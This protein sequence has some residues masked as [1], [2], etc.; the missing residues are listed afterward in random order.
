ME[1]IVRCNNE[2]NPQSLI[3]ESQIEFLDEG[4][5]VVTE[6]DFNAGAKCEYLQKSVWSN[7][8]AKLNFLVYPNPFAFTGEQ[9]E[10]S[11]NANLENGI[12]SLNE[13]DQNALKDITSEDI[14]N[15]DNN[16]QMYRVSFIH[17]FYLLNYL[18]AN[19]KSKQPNK[20]KC[21]TIA[22]E[23]YFVFFY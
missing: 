10:F 14:M 2:T 6:K 3:S 9:V 1:D 13:N 11:Q 12:F 22:P 7:V 5:N 19:G 17:A 23:H 16:M 15:V 18:L 20:F 8:Y 4:G 21:K